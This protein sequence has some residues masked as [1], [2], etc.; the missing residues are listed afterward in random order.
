MFSTWGEVFGSSLT[1]IVETLGRPTFT[2]DCEV[3]V[4]LELVDAFL[5][6]GFSLCLSYKQ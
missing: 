6:V 5:S 4:C 3:T 1:M 2:K